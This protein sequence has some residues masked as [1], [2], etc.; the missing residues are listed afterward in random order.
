MLGCPFAVQNHAIKGFTH[1][2][3]YGLSR[4]NGG[5]ETIGRQ[6]DLKT[7]M[8]VFGYLVSLV[9]IAVEFVER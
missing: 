7:D 5:L 1:R 9:G 6:I 3:S 2:F 4:L 8:L